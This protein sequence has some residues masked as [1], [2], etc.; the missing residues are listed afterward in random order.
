MPDPVAAAHDRR[1]V[2]VLGLGLM[3][4]ALARA[5]IRRGHP[6]TVWNRSREKA[7]PLVAL[8]ARPAGT[9]AEAFSAAGLAVVCLSGNDAVLRTCEPAGDALAGRTLVNLTSGTSS[10]A[11]GLAAWAAG[12]GADYLDGVLLTTPDAVGAPDTAVLYAGR[13]EVFDAH[14]P[15]LRALGGGLTRLGDDPGLAALYDLALLDMLWASL[16]GFLHAAALVATEHVKAGEFAPFA[17]L[18][19]AGLPSFV[20]RYARQIDEGAYAAED[21]TLETHLPA[22]GHL[23]AESLAR[24]VDADPPRRL[25][26][27]IEKAVAEGHGQDGYARVIEQFRKAPVPLEPSAG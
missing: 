16:N 27:V 11:R 2:A 18:L 19:F 1:P 3:G 23:L 24:G 20:A 25:R 8:G 5:F 7:G 21:S 10:E 14:R 15:T 9:P 17:D 13:R 6:T 22:A 12:R 26:A 4:S